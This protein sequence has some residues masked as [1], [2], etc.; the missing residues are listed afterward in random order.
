MNDF[1][2][3]DGPDEIRIEPV[4]P[5]PII[6]DDDPRFAAERADWSR[7]R[8]KAQAL[9]S[10]DE[11]FAGIR[12]TDWRVRFES[13]DRV[14]ARWKDDPR[15]IEEVLHAATAD[16]IWQVRDRAM[17]RLVEFD[18]E[19]VRPTLLMG[20]NDESEDVRWSAD[21]VLGQLGLSPDDEA[22]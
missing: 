12:D 19:K 14:V 13:I 2:P 20:L 1:P 8:A 18:A 3:E 11:L 10:A 17:M 4:G 9:H 5:I 15:T 21:Y 7:A 16:P 6:E 22:H